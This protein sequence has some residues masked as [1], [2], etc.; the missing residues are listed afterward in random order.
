M[1]NKKWL[2]SGRFSSAQ[3]FLPADV[4][5]LESKFGMLERRCFS[6]RM[7]RTVF[8]KKLLNVFKV[9]DSPPLFFYLLL[10]PPHPLPNTTLGHNVFGINIRL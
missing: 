9:K 1:E 4:T 5:Y 7:F 3:N 10:S 2:N 6:T 8:R